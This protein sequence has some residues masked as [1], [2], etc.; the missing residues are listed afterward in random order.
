MPIE[1][2]VFHPIKS[3]DVQ[4]QP[5]YAY[6][7]Y[8]QSS[9]G[10]TTE[11][12]F[13]RHDGQFAPVP[14][15]LHAQQHIYPELFNVTGDE[16][17]FQGRRRHKAT[18]WSGID[19]RYYRFPYDPGNTM[20]LSDRRVV[21][22]LLHVSCS[23]LTIPYFDVGEKIK[24]SSIS[25]SFDVSGS[26]GWAV[27]DDGHGN[28]RDPAVS[29][30][31]MAT[32][33]RNVFYMSF[34]ERFRD[35]R[36]T[37]Q[38]NGSHFGGT[39][40]TRIDNI[41]YALGRDEKFSRFYDA[42]NEKMN[43]CVGVTPVDQP[44]QVDHSKLKGSGYAA[45]FTHT[46]SYIRVPHDDLF[47]RFGR[48]D[49]WTIAF[50]YERGSQ[51]LTEDGISKV[52]IISKGAIVQEQFTD[53][54]TSYQKKSLKHVRVHSK[55]HHHASKTNR[56]KKDGASQLKTVKPVVELTKKTT[57]RIKTRDRNI[58]FPDIDQNFNNARTPFTI[59][60]V[61]QGN[62]T[63]YHFQS[64]DGEIS[65]HIS[66]SLGTTTSSGISSSLHAWQHVAVRNLNQTASFFINGVQVGTTG[67]IPDQPNVNH[68][69]VMFGRYHTYNVGFVPHLITRKGYTVDKGFFQ[70]ETK[71]DVQGRLILLPG[72]NVS[73][74]G[75]C[76]VSS[77]GS[78]HL[79]QGA[80][81]NIYGTLTNAGTITQED[82]S[83]LEIYPA[84]L[85]DNF[86]LAEFRMYDY[87]LNQ[88]NIES[89][90]NRHYMS[91]SLYQTNVVG[92]AFYKNAQLVISSPMPLYNSGSGA[93]FNNWRLRYRGTHKLY[94]NNVLV[95]VPQDTC[96]ISMNPSSTYQI[97]TV[98]DSCSRNQSNSIPGE[99]RKHMFVS[100]TA[101]PYVTT[102][103][104]YD[105]NCTLLAVGKMAQ[106]IQKRDDVDMNF[107]VRWDY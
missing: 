2:S 61:N 29:T 94:E 28:L 39:E 68:S 51:A 49:D 16:S 70:V 43:L 87:G 17:D 107:I 95:R 99:F 56:S 93:W 52:P 9:V 92:N 22:K 53:E 85:N 96:N 13:H 30:A 26:Y 42:I 103:G 50:W 67:S 25:A 81:L 65:L 82:G 63:T 98:G 27:K 90:A 89:L 15:P 62:T 37:Q 60:A 21:E 14:P 58:P 31:S 3:N 64:S 8:K 48:C 80:T 73:V 11:S 24:R 97:P 88:E 78:I 79:M 54:I 45:K 102:I 47:N 105:D 101:K 5:I 106:P 1:P 23:V 41:Q 35:I 40:L 72:A 7:H 34:N 55:L 77:I 44:L 57:K 83:E 100:G 75:R 76:A 69:D 84:W 74:R 20:E 10:F 104:L 6:K 36:E 91:G 32:S 33:S 38:F 18:I 59:G 71:L 86:G 4:Q 66:A 19:A 12:G 46:G